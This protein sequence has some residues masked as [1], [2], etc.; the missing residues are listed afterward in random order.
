M[1][2][3]IDPVP[4]KLTPILMCYSFTIDVY[5]NFKYLVKYAAL[6]HSNRVSVVYFLTVPINC[7]STDTFYDELMHT[8]RKSFFLNHLIPPDHKSYLR[9]STQREHYFLVSC[10]FK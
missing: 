2:A 6:I 8:P 10:Q 7:T 1:Q 3:V 9:F 5:F 4:D